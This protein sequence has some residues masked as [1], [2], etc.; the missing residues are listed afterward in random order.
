MGL[1]P[2]LYSFN[3]ASLIDLASFSFFK[4]IKSSPALA[5]PLI[6][7]ISTGVAGNAKSTLSPLSLTIALT[8]PH[9][10]PLTK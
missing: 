10:R 4:T 3:L 7:K 5:A 8:L 1:F 6:P 9:L 2:S